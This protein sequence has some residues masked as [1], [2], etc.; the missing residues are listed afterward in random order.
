MT[1]DCDRC[2]ARGPACGQC[3]V[4]FIVEGLL[5]GGPPAS[6]AAT[7][8]GG[9]VAGHGT[10]AGSGR[11]AGPGIELDAADLRALTVLASADM[12][13]PLRYA[14]VMAKAS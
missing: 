4:T 5:A 2:A 7:D 13:P 3:A 11:R 6:A 12:I 8:P 9:S 10:A 14:P 1:I